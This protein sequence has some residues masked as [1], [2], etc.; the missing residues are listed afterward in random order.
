MSIKGNIRKI[1]ILTT[2]CLASAGML[3]LLIAAINNRNGKACKGYKIT[4]NGV[5]NQS[6]ISAKAVENIITDSGVEKLDG[7]IISSFDLKSIEIKLKQNAWIN[8]AELFFDNN[9][10]L[11]V[12][13]TE[14]EPVARIFSNM[15]TNFYM[16]SSGMQLPIPA[17]LPVKLP[18]FTSYPYPGLKTLGADSIL[19]NDIKALSCFILRDSFWMAQIDQID[20]TGDKTF[21]L[22]PV[23][24]NHVIEFG[25]GSDFKIKFAR[26]FIFY[27]EVLSKT[28]FNKYTKI[29]V[30][31]KGQVIGTKKGSEISKS[32]SIRF[33]KEVGQLIR[34]AQQLQSDTVKQQIS[35]PLESNGRQDE[36]SGDVEFSGDSTKAK[37]D[38]AK[39]IKTGHGVLP[40]R[41]SNKK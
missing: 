22:I 11:R 21:E 26:L 20:I 32:D 10:I 7:K 18:V 15:E 39:S 41:G 38:A 13:I 8:N 19:L 1:I 2:W 34:S 23:V 40:V 17:G 29:D 16:D 12:N 37:R 36:A 6:F 3:V 30:Q 4:I 28:G 35:K 9:E 24:G 14:R 5:G 31:Y 27:K 33:L 25:N